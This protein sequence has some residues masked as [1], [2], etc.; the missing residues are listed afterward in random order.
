MCKDLNTEHKD[1]KCSG[2]I[3]T[4]EV[5]TF[6]ASFNTRAKEDKCAKEAH[7]ELLNMYRENRDIKDGLIEAGS[8][9]QAYEAV[10][11]EL[12]K[13]NNHLVFENKL[14]CDKVDVWKCRIEGLKTTVKV[15]E[16]MIADDKVTIDRQKKQFVRQNQDNVDNAEASKDLIIKYRGLKEK[17]RKLVDKNKDLR[18]SL[19]GHL[20]NKMDGANRIKTSPDGKTKTAKSAKKSK[21]S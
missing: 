4:E 6:L 9:L 20:K 15:L 19:L 10:Q 11:V 8:E 14:L 12:N 2:Y 5:K 1:C 21:K 7:M 13:I 16:S 17:N 18:A 3:G